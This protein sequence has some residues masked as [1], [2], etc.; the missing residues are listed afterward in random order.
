MT[1]EGIEPQTPVSERDDAFTT[2]QNPRAARIK[3][4]L[5][6]LVIYVTG[7]ESDVDENKISWFT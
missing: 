5:S 6:R 3:L 1:L 7:A 4:N 2:R